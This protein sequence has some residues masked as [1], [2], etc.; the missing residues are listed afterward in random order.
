MER[1]GFIRFITRRRLLD[2]GARSSSGQGWGALDPSTGV[3]ISPGLPSARVGGCICTPPVGWGDGFLLVFLFAFGVWRV[4]W[5]FFG[6]VLVL[7]SYRLD[8]VLLGLC[9][10][11]V[12]RGGGIFHHHRLALRVWIGEVSSLSYWV[13]V[14][15]G[16]M[17]LGL[18]V[19]GWS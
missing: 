9:L 12:C 15:P 17:F 13:M 6:G 1:L 8:T 10:C 4:F 7:F 16:L 14:S 11:L 19:G 2:C 5:G 18:R 3:R